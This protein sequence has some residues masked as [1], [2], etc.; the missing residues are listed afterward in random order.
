MTHSFG[1]GYATRSDE[2]GF[3]GVYGQNDPVFNPGTEVHPNHPG[4]R[5]LSSKFD[6]LQELRM[7]NFD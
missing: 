5:V 1:E 4:T 3:G 2:E 7:V 6:L